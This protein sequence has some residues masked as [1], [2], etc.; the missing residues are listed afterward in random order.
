MKFKKAEMGIGTLILF[1]AFILVAAVAASVLISTT[2]S[3]QSKALVTGKSTQTEVGTSMTAIEVYAE[4]ATSNNEVDYF[5]WT[6]KLS[7]G[8]DPLRFS[9]VLVTMNTNNISGEYSFNST[10]G[11]SVAANLDTANG[12]GISYSLQSDDFTAGYI[13]PGDVVKVC[14]K[15]PRAIGEAESIKMQVVP[16]VG[17]TLA[18]ETNM[19]ALMKDTR[20]YVFP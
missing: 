9:D 3:L 14:F 11:C 2:G 12:F 8:S 10:V 17:A 16:K 4:D 19:P 5:Y 1:I 20:V 13:F 6:L 15:A 7:S 18:V